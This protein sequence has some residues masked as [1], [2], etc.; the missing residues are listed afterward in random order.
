MMQFSKL[1]VRVNARSCS[2]FRS[3]R[4]LSTYYVQ[5]H[6]YIH[7]NGDVGTVGI[8]KHA[9]DALGDV[10]F[11]ELPDKGSDFSKGDSFGSVESVKAASDVYTPVSGEILEVNQVS[12][13]V[14]V[15]CIHFL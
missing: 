8:T 9:A 13:C 2:N 15:I 3:V 6:E 10:V 7:V 14:S 11:V 12:M 5:S 1:L 4:G